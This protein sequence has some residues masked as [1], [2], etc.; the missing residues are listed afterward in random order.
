[1]NESKE[2]LEATIKGLQEKINELNTELNVK[3]IE[4]NNVNKPE[5]TGEMYDSLESCVNEGIQ[6]ALS[7][8]KTDEIDVEYEI[9]YDGRVYLASFNIPE[10]GLIEYVMG[11][12]NNKFRIK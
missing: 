11:E 7:N 1:M 9:E 12:I 8:L 3:T 10:D 5:M 4:L 6:D 2:L